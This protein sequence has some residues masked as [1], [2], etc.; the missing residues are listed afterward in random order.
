MDLHAAWSSRGG[1]LAANQ[2]DAT[3]SPR[4]PGGLAT[5][6]RA[7][8]PMTSAFGSPMWVDEAR[9]A[10][11]RIGPRRRFDAHCRS[12]GP[13]ASRGG[14]RPGVRRER[15][16]A[17]GAALP[18]RQRA[19]RRVGFRLATL[20]PVVE[21]GSMSIVGPNGDAADRYRMVPWSPGRGR[22][23]R[24]TGSV[25]GKQSGLYGTTSR[26]MS[27]ASHR[28]GTTIASGLPIGVMTKLCDAC[29]GSAGPT[30]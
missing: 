4:V 3:T 26:T 6:D 30:A 18:L 10:V 23:C 27:Q 1:G 5:A 19:M 16:E 8:S 9:S 22:H 28:F 7:V 13:S 15:F 29:A 20:S 12:S 24:H 11:Q 25:E 17:S 21:T 14:D 2:H